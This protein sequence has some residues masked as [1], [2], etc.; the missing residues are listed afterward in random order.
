MAETI[1]TKILPPSAQSGL[2]ERIRLHEQTSGSEFKKAT[3]FIA[4]AGYGKT[5]YMTQLARKMKKPL[6]WYHMDSYDNDP[7][8][9][10]QYLCAAL[11]QQVPRFAQDTLKTIERGDLQSSIHAFTAML[12]NSLAIEATDGLIIAFDD[13]HLINNP[14]IHHFMQE[15]LEHLPSNL[16]LLIASR[17]PLPFSFDKMLMTGEI[18]SLGVEELRFDQKEIEIYL[19][20]FSKLK[21][22]NSN[23]N[24]LQEIRQTT[25]G[26]PVALR[27]VMETK[28]PIN[29][30]AKGKKTLFN[31]LAAEVLEKLPLNIRDFLLTTA[32]LDILTPDLC[33]LLMKRTDSKLILS[34]LVQEQLFVTQLS[35]KEDV[36]RYHQLFREFL[37]TQLGEDY[38][39]LL[40]KVGELLSAQ[41][42]WEQAVRYFIA[43]GSQEETISSLVKAG[44]KSL[45]SGRWQTVL[46]WLNSIPFEQQTNHPW[47]VLYRA[48]IEVY[49][50]CNE[51]AEKLA[52]KAFHL[53][54]ELNETKGLT[55]TKI[56]QARV[57]RCRGKFFESLDLLR[58]I[59]DLLPGNDQRLD[60]LM[61]KVVSLYLTGSF[62]EAEKF[63]IQALNSAEKQGNR[64]L[65]TYIFEGLG[66]VY[67]L[68]GDYSKALHFFKKG[69]EVSPEGFLPGY[70]T[71][72]HMAVI[73]QD[74]GELDQ[75]LNLAQRNVA[76]KEKLGLVE[77]LP[78]AY[79][80]LACIYTEL[81]CFKEAEENFQKAIT[82]LKENHGE[83]SYLALSLVFYGRSLWLQGKLVAAKAKTEEGLAINEIRDCLAYGACQSVGG[84]ILY[85]AGETEQG[86]QI[87]LE[88]IA[89]LEKMGFIKAVAYASQ[90]L[91]ILYCTEGNEDKFLMYA[92]KALILSARIDYIQNFITCFDVFFPILRVGMENNIE[93]SFIQRIIVRMGG[94]ARIILSPLLQHPDPEVRKRICA[95][96]SEIKDEEARKGLQLL[97]QD[98]NSQVSKTARNLSTKYKLKANSN[99]FYYTEQKDK[100]IKIYTLGRLRIFQ[101]N[102]EI[103]DSKWRTKK[104]KH[105][106]AYLAHQGEPVSKEK[107]IDNIWPNF[108]GE[109]VGALFHTTIYRLRQA[110]NHS[111]SCKI[112][113]YEGGSYQLVPGHYET[114]KKEFENYLLAASSEE[115]NQEETMIYLEKA[116]DLY[117][118]DYLEDLDYHWF[119]PYQERLRHLYVSTR[120]KLGRYYMEKNDYAKAVTHLLSLVGISYLSEE[121]HSL[122]MK[123][124]AGLGD[125]MAVRKQFQNMTTVFQEELGLSPSPDIVDLYYKLVGKTVH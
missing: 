78:S 80:H 95:P 99:Q 50:G 1:I 98:Q 69:I 7:V 90:A 12:I 83:L 67:Y 10:F 92:K 87:L 93:L 116:V 16:H 110:L 88:S 81:G 14:L 19:Q 38:F 40:H 27:L 37:L 59:E 49:R 65:L 52:Q 72:D 94:R 32:V 70:H 86:K 114:D 21:I 55:Q 18:S 44:R 11:R 51:Q 73:Y 106:L 34:N 24:L 117:R 54:T 76:F 101:N 68:K 113:S 39:R 100:M 48:E 2:I 104:A 121:I 122:L 60:L 85:Q 22:S 112:I 75:A 41:G 107:I 35:G 45:N 47:L 97:A 56:L 120:I 115:L 28:G 31:Y 64:Y 33:N 57:F 124:Y 89:S 17:A 71:Q 9:F 36:Y 5:V 111:P 84:L 46:E 105:L 42:E 118:G 119:L 77:T 6:V 103:T 62:L 25:E 4:P 96:L 102:V 125:I 53:F 3:L 109:E 8:V 20:Q 13:L 91:A 15:F 79:T 61:E 66:N 26:W 23:Q 82:L 58:Q 74:W 123:A 108:E 29:L 30:E 43:A 63:L